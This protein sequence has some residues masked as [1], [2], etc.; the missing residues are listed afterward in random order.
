MKLKIL[1]LILTCVLTV[2]LMTNLSTLTV[3][4]V[5]DDDPR[6]SFDANGGSGYMP[7]VYTQGNYPLPECEFTA[8]EGY[9][10]KC[11]H[12]DG[13]I[14]DLQPGDTVYVGSTDTVVN[15]VWEPIPAK[16]IFDNGGGIGTMD[17]VEIYGDYM[18]PNCSFA[19]PDGQRFEAWQFDNQEKQ[20]GDSIYVDSIITVTAL[21]EVI[22]TE[23]PTDVP[24]PPS[25][26]ND[27]NQLQNTQSYISG[28]N[29]QSDLALVI[30]IVL[31]VVLILAVCVTGG[32][33][34]VLL[35][36]TKKRK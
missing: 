15:A 31:G 6:I 17:E 24:T 32:I 21:W 16:V 4:A 30:A 26:N 35:A 29:A 8:P 25:D 18:L 34:I 36:M 20:P 1:S 33:L 14:R 5:E 13:D 19:A 12:R 22:P 23:A 28:D 27:T 7:T 3:Y 9:R 2:S 11:W 10:F